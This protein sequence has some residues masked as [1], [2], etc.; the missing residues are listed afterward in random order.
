MSGLGFC[1]GWFAWFWWLPCGGSVFGGGGQVVSCSIGCG[2][3]CPASS[4]WQGFFGFE[5][6]GVRGGQS[7]MHL[8]GPVP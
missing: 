6:W 3:R 8:F 5:C 2:C 1:G 7:R 4:S